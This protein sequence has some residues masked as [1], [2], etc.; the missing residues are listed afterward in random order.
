MET[1]SY[2]KHEL[3][4]FINSEHFTRLKKL[5]ISR[6]RAISQINNPRA[7]DD[8][9]LLIVQ[10]DK[11]QVVGY[12]GVL[13]DYL[14]NQDEIQKVGWLTCFWSDKAYKSNNIA[15]NLFLRVIRAWDQKIFITNLVPWHERL[16]QRT[17]MFLP[18]SYKKGFRGYMRFNLSE[19]LPPKRKLYKKLYLLLKIVDV[20]SNLVSD[21]RFVLFR[22]YQM[23]DMNVEACDTVDEAMAVFIENHNRDNWNQRGKN[24]LNWILKYPWVI[25]QAQPDAES[26]KYY[27]SSVSTRFFYKLLRFTGRDGEVKGLTM[28][29]I[30]NNSLTVPYVF[31]EDN[32]YDSIARAL[33]NDMIKYKLS[34][35]TAFDNNLAG[36]LQKMRIPFIFR[37]QIKKPFLISKNFGFITELKF[38]DGDGDC[39]F[40]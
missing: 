35:V 10:F 14:K 6:H 20:L 19:I 24:E 39:A 26:E 4:D 1:R 5:P 2:N 40:Y 28:L 15:A 13:P 18:T 21:S 34:M 7:S 30:R 12:L 29:C 32:C 3:L 8:D 11:E 23:V 25:Q 22:G 16:Y 31:A 38:Q 37:K 36:S 17:R 33:V 27:F 9:I